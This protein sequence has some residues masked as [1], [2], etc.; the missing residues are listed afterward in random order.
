MPIVRLFQD[1]V[2]RKDIKISNTWD[3]VI[4]K[5]NG[6]NKVQ[7]TGEN[8]VLETFLQILRMC[9]GTRRGSYSRNPQFGCS[10][11]G[12]K[13]KMTK[14]SLADLRSYIKINLDGSYFNQKDYPT[15]VE[16][17]QISPD[18]VAVSINIFFPLGGRDNNMVS[19]NVLFNESTQELKP[20]FKAFGE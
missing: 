4:K 9:L 11:R 2:G 15:T 19:L 1:P 7:V 8:N 16:V 20:V 3:I 13:F 18:T 14:K 17:F 10:P 6:G 12:Q 5:D